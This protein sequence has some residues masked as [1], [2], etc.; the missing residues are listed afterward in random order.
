MNCCGRLCL[1]LVLLV[2]AGCAGPEPSVSPPSTVAATAAP[3][4]TPSPLVAA[5]S[6]PLVS[7]TAT[8]T[9][10]PL[11][12]LQLSL[13]WRYPTQ[14]MLWS[15]ASADLEGD[16]AEEIIA[17]SYD[18]YV[19]ALGHDGRLLW[20]YRTGAPIYC[21]ATGDLDGDGDMEVVV[22]GDDNRVHVLQTD[23]APLW[24][25]RTETRVTSLYVGDVD[26]DRTREVLAG[27]WDGQLW[28]LGVEGELRWQLESG[29][30]LSSV[31]LVDLEGDGRREV[32]AGHQDGLVSLVD[33][34]GSVRWTYRTG[35]YVRE[36]AAEDIDGDAHGEIIVGSADG[37]LYVLSG[38]GDLEWKRSLGDPVL[39]VDVADVDGDGHA[40]IV[41]G[42][43][44]HVPKIYVLSD[45]GEPRWTYDVPKSVWVVRA[46]DVDGDGRSE[47]LAGGDDGIVRILDEY[48]RLR[49]AY[50]TERRVHGL[51]VV[52]EPVGEYQDI[53][54]RSGNDVYLLTMNA[55]ETQWEE[56]E[57]KPDADTLPSWTGPLPGSPE[58]GE[59]LVELVAVGDIMLSRTVEERTEVFGTSYPLEAVAEVLRS[60]DIAIGNLESPLSVTGEPLQKRF[61]FRAHPGHAEA[62][63]HAGIDVVSLANNH[64]LDYGEEGFVE[65]LEALRAAGVSHVGA[66]LSYAEAHTPLI[67][68]V[69]GRRIAF[70][71]YA[72]SRWEGSSELPT[73]DLVSFADLATIREDVRRAGE[74][75]DLVVV[76]MHLGTEYQRY[77]DE[78]QL[79]VSRAAIEAGACLVI[80]HHP[81][82][83]QAVEPYG[84]GFVAYSLGDFVFDIDVG[85]ATR[86]GSILRVLLGDEGVQAID[87]LPVRIVDDV[88]PRLLVGE[89]GHPAVTEVFRASPR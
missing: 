64:Q 84:G 12:P 2:L 85:D 74:L 38:E 1:I 70:L 50:R 86:Y 23:G 30:G 34:D 81:H 16:G 3:S 54:V 82:V 35:G 73:R 6:T 43:G 72:A 27:G 89:D 68:E 25:W 61:L 32:L 39:T 65:T 87:L 11:V 9:P 77:P 56:P 57:G 75:A 58:A 7:P 49:G 33:A 22:G 67:R 76:I 17:A 15:V 62:L 18:K 78:E 48:G 26:G 69:K 45:Q 51:S 66:G 46:A 28:M 53:A 13:A 88:Q 63:A 47:V 41:A 59:D 10:T 29:E 71:A 42:T 31:Q 83:V 80:G 44:P 55:T 14:E 40:E 36:L 79:A 8:S 21:L 4:A 19:Y 5:T 60:A 37:W 20:R 24:E 52:R